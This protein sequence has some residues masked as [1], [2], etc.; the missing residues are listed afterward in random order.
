M[1]EHNLIRTHHGLKKENLQKI[2]Y[3]IWKKYEKITPMILTDLTDHIWTL[4][5]LLT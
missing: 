4:K 1:A 2:K 5:E 3:N